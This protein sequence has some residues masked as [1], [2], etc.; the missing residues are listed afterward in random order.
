MIFNSTNLIMPH[1]FVQNK[2]VQE[3]VV[4]SLLFNVSLL[5][6][7]HSKPLVREGCKFINSNI[8][9]FNPKLNSMLINCQVKSNS[10]TRLCYIH[11]LKNNKNEIN[12]M[13]LIS[14]FVDFSVR[15]KVQFI[16][17]TGFYYF[18]I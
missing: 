5:P 7:C 9:Q 6:H 18:T 1:Q 3:F 8:Y 16:K 14:I 15:E 17:A 13:I 4:V 2:F 12:V 10:Q 11:T